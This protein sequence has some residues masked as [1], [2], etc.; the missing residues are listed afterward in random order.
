ML[1]IIFILPSR[2]KNKNVIILTHHVSCCMLAAGDWVIVVV[3]AV[4]ALAFGE[5]WK[6]A[7]GRVNSNKQEKKN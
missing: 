1:F 5:L 7:F 4:T 6:L 2:D 3:L